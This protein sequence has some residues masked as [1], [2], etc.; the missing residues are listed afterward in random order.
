VPSLLEFDFRLPFLLEAPPV[1]LVRVIA[2]FNGAAKFVH[3]NI[4]N[5]GG[6]AHVLDRAPGGRRVFGPSGRN[7]C[8]TRNLRLG[9][10][11]ARG[12]SGQQCYGRQQK[13]EKTH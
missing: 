5:G 8:N 7:I 3:I 12:T 13:A 10:G 2:A 9:R 6:V 11:H 1:A 4:G